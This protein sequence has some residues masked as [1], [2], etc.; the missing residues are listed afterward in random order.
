MERQLLATEAQAETVISA[1][2]K[3]NDPDQEAPARPGEVAAREKSR[4][5]RNKRRHHSPGKSRENVSDC[6]EL[7]LL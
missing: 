4:S 1:A 3:P 2:P 6:R 5:A 7:G